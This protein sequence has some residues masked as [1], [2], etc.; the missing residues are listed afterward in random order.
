MTEPSLT[1]VNTIRLKSQA[2]ALAE[3]NLVEGLIAL[4]RDI[5]ALS[6]LCKR[7]WLHELKKIG[8]HQRVAF[9]FREI[10]R[11]WWCSQDGPIG[12]ALAQQLPYDLHKL[13]WLCRLSKEDLE[14]L[15]KDL[16]PQKE[17][18]SRV[19]KA[20]QRRLGLKAPSAKAA[21]I[22]PPALFKRW[23]KN[24]GNTLDLIEAL[25]DDAS[26][27]VRKDLAR[28]MEE[29][30]FE[31]QDALDPCTL[32]EETTEDFEGVEVGQDA[33]ELQDVTPSVPE[34]ASAAS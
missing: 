21:K 16:D 2:L 6:V 4:A 20:A 9:R 11:S 19:I 32:D 5:N 15:L 26:I 10:G 24:V 14:E 22:T 17:G 13:E 12:S 34:V 23:Q 27:E 1:L 3:G 8:L 28:Q 30:F 25:G 33:E 7:K 31:I 29:E 18:R